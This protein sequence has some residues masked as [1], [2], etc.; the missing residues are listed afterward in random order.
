M[1]AVAK[2]GLDQVRTTGER[3]PGAG[4]H[5]DCPAVSVSRVVAFSG[6]GGRRAGEVLLSQRGGATLGSLLGGLADSKV[7]EVGQ[8]TQLFDVAIGD[9]D[10][11]GAGLACGGVATVLVT[12]LEAVPVRAWE[13]LDKGRPLAMVTLVASAA[14]RPGAAA[15]QPFPTGIVAVVDD[16]ASRRLQRHGSLGQED[17]DDLAERAA[18]QALRLG[19]ETSEVRAEGGRT[20]VVEVYLP[21]TTL[22]VIGEGKVAGALSA[23]GELLGWAIVVD[24]ELGA[25]TRELSRALGPTD[26]L[27]VL[28]H[29][30]EIDTDALALAL[31]TDCYVGALGSRHTQAARKDRL[32]A[33]GVDE[34]ALGRI[35]GPVG[36]DLGARTPEET[37]VSITAEILAHRSGRGAASLISSSGPING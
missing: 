3:S 28:S 27:V 25:E 18:R 11:I 4:D 19:R 31:S 35:H 5:R 15:G 13:A 29:D 33:L 26:A 8:T 22:V 14:D 16:P 12:P 10:A 20:L 34:Q 24:A 36:L 7:A 9:A 30:P 6:L 2:A 32:R 17:L 21:A 23:Q 37:A 1:R